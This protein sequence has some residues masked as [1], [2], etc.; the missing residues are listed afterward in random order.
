M[1]SGSEDFFSSCV[2]FRSIESVGSLFSF[3]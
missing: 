2:V 1:S 3:L